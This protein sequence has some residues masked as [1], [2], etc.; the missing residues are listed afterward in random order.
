M[1]DLKNKI[2]ML[3]GGM[4][5]MLQAAGVPMG[6]VPEA[7]NVTHGEA[8][9]DIHRQYIEAGADIIYANTFSAN[10]YK[11]SYSDYSVEELVTAGVKNAKKRLPIPGEMWLWL[12]MWD[13]SG[14]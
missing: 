9:I 13:L 5:T 6:K 11:L 3:D 10:R 12:W 14:N 7:L 2:I 1:L 8:V 4:G